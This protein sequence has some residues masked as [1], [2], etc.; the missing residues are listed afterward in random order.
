[1][2]G[3]D[4]PLSDDELADIFYQGMID[5]EEDTLRESENEDDIS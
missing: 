1:M 2:T 5:A 4:D 3:P